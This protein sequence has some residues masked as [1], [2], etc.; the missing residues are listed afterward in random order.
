MAE[1]CAECGEKLN[2]RSDKKFCSSYCR[3]AFYNR[4]NSDINNMMRNINRILS[5][6]RRILAS[7]NKNGKATVRKSKLLQLGFT[8]QYFTS[9]YTNKAG[10]TYYFCY[11]QG[12]LPLEKG[13]VA[14]VVRQDYTEPQSSGH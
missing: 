14:L 9:T 10:K 11:D 2:G 3:T 4:R 8:Y 7:L 13:L 6:N 1:S 12:Y 5:K